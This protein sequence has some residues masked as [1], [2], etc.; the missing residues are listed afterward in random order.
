MDYNNNYT[1]AK[2]DCHKGN[3][4][5]WKHPKGGTL[6]IG[7]W[8]M[9]ATFNYNTHVIDLTGSEHR[10]WDIP[11]AYDNTSQ[12]FMP[13]LSKTY[14]GWLSLPFPDFGTP[15][16]LT[17]LDQW[18][19]IAGVIEDIL[20]KGTDVLVACQGGHGRSG[21][22]CAIVGYLLAVRTDRSWSSPV[23]KIR[24]LHCPDSVETFE[25][26]RYVYGILGLSITIK[27]AYVPKATTAYAENMEACPICGT[28]SYFVKDTGMCA[29][30]KSK[31]EKEAPT[32]TDLT[33][34][35]IKHKGLVEHS[36]RREK[37]VGIWRAAKC[38]HV[39]HDQIVYEGWCQTCW[40][41]YQDDIEYAEAQLQREETKTTSMGEC[42]ICE[43]TT[44][45]ALRFG[46]CYDC[47]EYLVHK[48]AVDAVHN[49]ITDP[50]K[51]VP[52]S[53]DDDG[54]VG[55]VMADVCGHVVHNME[56]ED[57]KC[58]ECRKDELKR[59]HR[60]EDK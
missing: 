41:K 30:C 5:V 22:F 38:N 43:K 19:G 28:M 47:S 24:K 59:N 58:P 2:K 33:A 12:A 6:Y 20:S 31:Y 16:G 39:I 3:S 11:L 29:S 8:N 17:T 53:C 37:C 10:L 23:E 55:I 35:D 13:F 36:C 48:N 32:R 52:H 4:I 9:G 50:Y 7:G 26:E 45:Y 15:K 18:K 40:D 54:C 51:A 44:M 27:H 46:V 34:E 60:T 25:Q 14:A 49:S 21:L 56:I 42:A 1:W 57:G